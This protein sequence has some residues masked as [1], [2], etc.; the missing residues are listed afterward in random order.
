MYCAVI[1]DG[2]VIV[3]FDNILSD[4]KSKTILVVAIYNI[5]LD[6]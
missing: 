1:P 5:I 2:A 4:C 3:G 6:Y